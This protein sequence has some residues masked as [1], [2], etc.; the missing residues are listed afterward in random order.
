MFKNFFNF[1]YQKNFKS[2]SRKRFTLRC[3]HVHVTKPM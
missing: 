3:A 1:Q 2:A